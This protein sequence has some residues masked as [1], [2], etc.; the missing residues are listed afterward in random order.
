MNGMEGIQLTRLQWEAM[1]KLV[2]SWLPEEACGLLGGKGARVLMIAPVTNALRS[3]TRFRMD[4]EGQLAGM[5]KIEE[6]GFDLIGIY[7]SHPQGPGGLSET[8]L[9]EMAYPE[10]VHLIWSLIGGNWTCHAFRLE[11]EEPIEIPMEM[12]EG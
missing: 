1:R 4:P 5:Q 7:H 10:L 3:F 9:K 12:I 2:Q 11:A 8:D 6:G